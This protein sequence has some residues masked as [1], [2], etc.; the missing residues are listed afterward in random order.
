[1]KGSFLDRHTTSVYKIILKP[2][3]FIDTI[4]NPND[5]FSHFSNLKLWLHEI[6]P[7]WP[8]NPIDG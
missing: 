5:Q 1:M 7:P 4:L 2:R 3:E 8:K 6:K